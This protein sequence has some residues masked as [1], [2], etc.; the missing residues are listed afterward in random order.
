MHTQQIFHRPTAQILLHIQGICSSRNK[1]I[2]D[3]TLN[4]PNNDAFLGLFYQF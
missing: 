4:K 1:Q 3:I 2:M